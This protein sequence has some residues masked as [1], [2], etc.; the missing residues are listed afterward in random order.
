[1]V[2][3]FDMRC[4]TRV[5][6]QSA[7]DDRIAKS[8]HRRITRHGT[9]FRVMASQPLLIV[10]EV[11]TIR[12]TIHQPGEKQPVNPARQVGGFSAVMRY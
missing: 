5:E 6:S 8:G 4:T 10:S 1:M 3:L 2:P 11:A 7:S 9:G 12:Y